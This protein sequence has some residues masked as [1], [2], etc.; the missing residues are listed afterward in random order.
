V[1]GKVQLCGKLM[2]LCIFEARHPWLA[3]Q[4]QHV[5]R[6]ELLEMLEAWMSFSGQNCKLRVRAKGSSGGEG[7]RGGGI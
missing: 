6:G 3:I 4:P 2:G 1:T 5:L 7:G